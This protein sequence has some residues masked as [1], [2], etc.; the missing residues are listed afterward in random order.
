MTRNLFIASKSL[1]LIQT[2]SEVDGARRLTDVKCGL[3]SQCKWTDQMSLVLD[4]ALYSK[5]LLTV[6]GPR[7]EGILS[8]VS[9]PFPLMSIIVIYPRTFDIQ[10]TLYRCPGDP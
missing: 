1:A 7:I 4:G 10:G 9:G 2:V 5:P 8:T 3:P 6:L